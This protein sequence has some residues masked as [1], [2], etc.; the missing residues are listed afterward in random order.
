MTAD[1]AVPADDRVADDGVLA[2]AG[3]GPDDGA[4]NQRVFFDQCLA[5]DD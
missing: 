1:V 5:S 4:V 3:I 2:D